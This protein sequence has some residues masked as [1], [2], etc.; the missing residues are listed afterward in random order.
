MTSRRTF[1]QNAARLA[2]ALTVLPR[3][4][5]VLSPAGTTY[6]VDTAGDNH[7]SGTSATQAWADFTN[8]NARTFQPGD[9]ILLKRGCI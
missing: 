7:D 4:L 8:I 2:G 5:R 6:Y 3:G 9:S 1:F